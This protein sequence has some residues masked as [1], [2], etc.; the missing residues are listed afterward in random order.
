LLIEL[1]DFRSETVHVLIVEPFRMAP[2]NPHQP[3][4]RFFG[5]LH[6]PGRGPDT[7][8]FTQMA[9]DLFG[10]GLRALRIEQGGAAS[11]GKFFTAGATAQQAKGITAIDLSDD[12][13]A[14]AT[15]AKELA[16]RIDT[17]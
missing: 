1:Q 10:F 7:T 12:E 15:L 4:H 6:E 3:G 2:S 11:L 8:A 16:C 17:R 5:T 14:L 13:I 9:N